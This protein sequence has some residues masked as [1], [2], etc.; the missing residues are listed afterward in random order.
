MATSSGLPGG[1]RLWGREQECA[2][3]DELV[4]SVRRGESC[5]LVLTGEAGIGKSAL[6]QYLVASA[7]AMNIVR[8]TGV[9][10][11]MGL[12]YAGLHQLC[13]PLLGGIDRLPGPQR[14]ALRTAF[15]ETEGL[16]PDRFLVDLP[17]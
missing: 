14:D 5:S 6:L 9:E 8:A 13:T 7:D 16:A 10:S 1:T 2:L 15:G 3:L 11:D 17:R 12:P 4:S